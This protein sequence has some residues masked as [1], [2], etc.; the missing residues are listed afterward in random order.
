MEIIQT[1]FCGCLRER[2]REPRSTVSRESLTDS[3]KVCV[4]VCVSV[5]VSVYVCVCV[6]GDLVG[7]VLETVVLFGWYI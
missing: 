7:C 5:Y 2:K 4:C 3:H 1:T 6:T